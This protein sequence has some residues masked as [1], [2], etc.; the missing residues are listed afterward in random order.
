VLRKTLGAG[1]CAIRHFPEKTAYSAAKGG[2]AKL[3][4]WQEVRTVLHFSGR[5]FLDALE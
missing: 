5:N 1:F 2:G 3:L 4:Y